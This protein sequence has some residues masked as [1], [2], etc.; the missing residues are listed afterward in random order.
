MAGLLAQDVL[1]A[2]ARVLVRDRADLVRLELVTGDLVERP[3][4]VAHLVPVVSIHARLEQV[5]V[6]GLVQALALAQL[7]PRVRE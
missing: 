6:R 4:P 3:V 7:P 1:P 5:R 2:P